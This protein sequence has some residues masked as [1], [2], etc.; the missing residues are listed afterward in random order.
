MYAYYRTFDVHAAAIKSNT[1]LTTVGKGIT[2][3]TDPISTIPI[4]I[5]GKFH[6]DSFFLLTV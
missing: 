4:K 6:Q 5:S 3:I 1:I 2:C